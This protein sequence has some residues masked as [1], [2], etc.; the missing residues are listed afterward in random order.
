MVAA[1]H[2][3]TAEVGAAVL[4]EGGN[5]ADAAIAAVCASFVAESPLTGFGAGGFMLVHRDGESSLLDFFVETPGRDSDGVRAELIPVDILFDGTIQTFNT[6]AA[7]CG[8]PGTPAGL[9][10]AITTFG[11][12]DL[13][14]VVAPAARMAREGVAVTPG[15]AYLHEV[16]E[17]ILTATPEAQEL[18]APHG[19]LLR[20]GDR[21]RW[22]ELADT[23]ARYGAEGSG[24]FAD[25]DVGRALSAWV[26][27]RGGEVGVADLQA[28]RPIA[29]DPVRAR[30][31]GREI[32][33]NAPPS[34]GGI[35]IAFALELLER[36]GGHGIAELVGVMEEANASRHDEF[37]R[38]LYDPAFAR[39]YLE[40]GR[41]DAAADRVRARLR[42]GAPPLARSAG[43]GDQ[44]GSTTHIAVV[45]ADGMAV[46][47]TCSNGSGSAVVVPGTGVHMNNMLGEEDLSPHGFHTLPAGVRMTSMMAPTLILRDGAVEAALGSAGS[48]RLRSAIVQTACHMVIDGLSPQQAIDAGRVHTEAGVVH[49]EPGVDPSGLA[50]VEARGF[51]I[52]RWQRRNLFFGGAQA[53]RRKADGSKLQGGG[54][55]RRGGAAE[56]A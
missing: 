44:L 18:Y 27:Q 17:P 30:F 21:F 32:L 35:L 29:R 12:L 25:G 24:L 41:L 37:H 3:Q 20:A 33:T 50:A 45:D 34:S 11:T 13:A 5:A 15:Q 14:E 19:R 55:P 9:A 10:E 28:Y 53:V 16:L 22:I 46:S 36:V 54:D 6:G 31:A 23:L 51:E 26:L 38:S 56:T 47:V 49:A 4:R 8:V 52:N 40:S 39:W 43:P 42:T 1:G 2:P 7:S 48:N